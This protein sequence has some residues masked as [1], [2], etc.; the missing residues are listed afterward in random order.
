[1]S[2]TTTWK[3]E[4]NRK[5]VLLRG[6]DGN[7][8]THE[9]MLM[10]PMYFAERV[11]AADD[12]VSWEYTLQKNET[13]FILTTFFD[14][15]RVEALYIGTDK[16][17]LD[18]ESYASVLDAQERFG[19]KSNDLYKAFSEGAGLVVRRDPKSLP[20]NRVEDWGWYDECNKTLARK[21]VVRLAKRWRRARATD[22]KFNGGN[23]MAAHKELYAWE[24]FMA[25]RLW[26][27]E[28]AS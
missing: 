12:G 26:L 17:Y 4:T 1:M 25:A 19:I 14:S 10:T 5:A 7:C 18:R 16:K 24:T 22:R 11:S 20:I 8:P 2:Y 28:E 9:Y 15:L 6:V 3:Q 13:L 27:K 21:I 23:L